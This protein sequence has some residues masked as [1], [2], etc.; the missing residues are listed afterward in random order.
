[1]EAL[2]VGCE[3]LGEAPHDSWVVADDAEWVPVFLELAAHE[4]G[5]RLLLQGA[6]SRP[7]RDRMEFKQAE[8]ILNGG[9]RLVRS[10]VAI[11]DDAGIGRLW[12]LGHEDSG[13]PGWIR[14]AA[15][16]GEGRKGLD[17]LSAPARDTVP[18]AVERQA[19]KGIGWK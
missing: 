8:Q 14:Q 13:L 2:A 1:L 7:R 17:V 4:S 11:A 18:R 9:R 12:L 10:V 19:T 15:G 3:G 6:A 16:K 5:A